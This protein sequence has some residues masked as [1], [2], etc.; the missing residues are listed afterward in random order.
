MKWKLLKHLF[1]QTSRQGFKVRAEIKN[2]VS[3]VKLK[4]ELKSRLDMILQEKDLEHVLYEISF[5]KSIK[6]DASTGKK[7]LIVVKEI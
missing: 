2:T 1:V 3:K 6:P 5:V 7:R 4:K